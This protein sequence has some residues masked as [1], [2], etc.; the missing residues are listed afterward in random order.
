[1][2]IAI[3]NFSGNVGK[4]T[5]CQQLLVPRL[6]AGCPVFAVETINA[7]ASDA[8]EVERLK[9]KQFGA[10]QE[11]LLILNDAIIDVGASNV[12]DFIKYMGQFHGSHEDYDYF[13][14][15]IV[16]D[17]KQQLDSINTI[18]TLAKFR[19]DK[20]RILTVFNKVN[21]EDVD[22][23]AS[24]FDA[25]F[26]FEEIEKLFTLTPQA[27]IFN[28]EVFERIRPLKK[29]ISEIEEDAMDYRQLLRD[30]KTDDE[31]ENAIKMISIKRL[32]TSAK[33][34]LDDVFD[35]L[36]SAKRKK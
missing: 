31:K 21:I 28:N 16:A 6:P 12:E 30:A 29:S 17:Q 24:T 25:I 19:V 14:I 3:I 10:L 20:K 4:T 5:I 15:P 2:K 23:L 33:K 35:C 32:A 34:N 8:N 22:D 7:G 1:M 26:G 36:F 13:L 27:V 9:G 18:K 11:Q